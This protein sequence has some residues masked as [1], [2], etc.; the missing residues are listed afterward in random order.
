MN[1]SGR[2]IWIT[3]LPGAGK[4][5]VATGLL[6][7][8][9]SRNT[10]AI[11]LDGDELRSVFR[12]V[13]DQPFGYDRTSRTSLAMQFSRLCGVLAKQGFTVL[14]ATVSLIHEIHDWN[15]ENLPGYCEVF[16]DVPS[17]ELER[18]DPKG[19]YR[20]FRAGELM[21]L[22]GLDIAPE[23]PMNPHIRYRFD[24]DHSAGRT[25]EIVMEAID[26]EYRMRR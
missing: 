25:I 20:G 15:R 4:S 3:G 19:L 13:G 18:R 14:M 23:F 21:N 9:L 10:H 7:V 2:V 8:L 1:G 16:I 5:T 12:S 6:N 26:A 22:P 24:P 11:L 17:D